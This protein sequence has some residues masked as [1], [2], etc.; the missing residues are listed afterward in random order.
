MDKR[1]EINL[2]Q[3]LSFGSEK[4]LHDLNCYVEQLNQCDY[5]T[6]KL[7]ICFDTNNLTGMDEITSALFE[8]Q[9]IIAMLNNSYDHIR[10]TF[11]EKNGMIDVRMQFAEPSRTTRRKNMYTLKDQSGLVRNPTLKYD[12]GQHCVVTKIKGGD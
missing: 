4:L 6:S 11:E 9:S 3:K 5:L 1:N 7:V 10:F 12:S 8:Y 2:P